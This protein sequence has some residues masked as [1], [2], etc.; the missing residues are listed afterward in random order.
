M[1]DV[2]PLKAYQILEDTLG[3]E[4]AQ[5]LAEVLSI[6]ISSELMNTKESLKVEIS[7]ELKKELATKYDLKILEVE[8]R[9]EIDLVR[10]DMKIMEI[11]LI[12]IIVIINIIFNPNALE[13]LGKLFGIIK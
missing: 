8:L 13:L 10:K 6:H 4:K 11:R 1:S 7:E 3:K 9:K 12:A 2:I 5:E